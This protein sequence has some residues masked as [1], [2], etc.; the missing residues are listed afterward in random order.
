MGP[1][2]NYLLSSQSDSK[3]PH[4]DSILYFLGKLEPI[5]LDRK[6]GQI[7]ILRQ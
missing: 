3:Q 1:Y 4:I 5:P 6:L 7:I 2:L